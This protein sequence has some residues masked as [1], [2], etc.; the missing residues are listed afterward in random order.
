M[1]GISSCLA[2]L[3]AATALFSGCSAKSH[4]NDPRQPIPTVISVAVTAKGV[5]VE[6]E[7]VGLP[8]ERQP[9]INQNR[10]APQNQAERGVPLDVKFAL[11][12]A[13]SVR[14]RLLLAGPIR[15]VEPL[16]ANGSGS[17]TAGLPT[18]IYRLS[19]NLS[20]GTARLLV[21]PSRVSSSGD[22]LTP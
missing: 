4:E 14:G 21:G 20:R 18:G 11:A 5:E 9:N 12:N 2:A 15:R 19:S 16:F 8:L 6:P 1:R 10:T 3:F 22:L 13:T 7:A 17:F